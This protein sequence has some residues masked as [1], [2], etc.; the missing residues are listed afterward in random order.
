MVYLY[1]FNDQYQ[2]KFS[3]DTLVNS[4]R[5]YFTNKTPEYWEMFNYG[6][7][8]DNLDFGMQIYTTLFNHAKETSEH[9]AMLDIRPFHLLYDHKKMMTLR[10]KYLYDNR[11]LIEL[12]QEHI[13]EYTAIEL[14]A[15]ILV[16]LAIK[17]NLTKDTN[18]SESLQTLIMNI[19]NEESIFLERWLKKVGIQ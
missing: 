14:K 17:Y 1:T 3:A 5:N 2:D 12:N 15:K 10:F 18:T 7:D 13:D 4:I 11:H 6:G 19:E 9:K 16:N 8:R